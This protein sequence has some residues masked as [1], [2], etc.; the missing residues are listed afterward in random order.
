MLIV[1]AKLSKKKLA[2]LLAATI[3]GIVSLLFLFKENSP[4]LPEHTSPFSNLSSNEA[5]LELLASCGLEAVADPIVTLDLQL[6]SPLDERYTAYNQLQLPQG[7]DLTSYCGR[8]LTR[9]TYT[10]TNH[11]ASHSG[12]QANL[13]L[14]EDTLVAAD[15]FCAG[16]NGFIAPL[17]AEGKS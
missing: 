4:P 1:T 15:L 7:F 6:P 16:E 3:I 11:A 8:Q 17:F 10:I 13:Y 2:F 5:R 14:F 9:Y 12:V